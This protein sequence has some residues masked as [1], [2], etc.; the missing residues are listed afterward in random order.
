[1]IL[2]IFLVIRDAEICFVVYILTRMHADFV[3][4]KIH[5][6]VLS[7][8]QQDGQTDLALILRYSSS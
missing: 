8:R 4:G 2:Y 6:I 1:M 7:R 3:H 5:D